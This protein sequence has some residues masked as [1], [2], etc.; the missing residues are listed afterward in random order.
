MH[1]PR[2]FNSELTP[3]KWWDWK[4]ILSCWGPVYFQ[5]LVLL[6][7]TEI[8]ETSVFTTGGLKT[9]PSLHPINTAGFSLPFDETEAI[10]ATTFE[11]SDSMEK[12][13]EPQGKCVRLVRSGVPS[14]ATGPHHRRLRRKKGRSSKFNLQGGE[15]V[16]HDYVGGI[17]NKDVVAWANSSHLPQLSK[18]FCQQKS[19]KPLQKKTMLHL[20]PSTKSLLRES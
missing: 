7:S 13:Q 4:T 3:E 14:G 18:E 6:V 9:T 16:S 10:I 17:L 15:N 20:G 19:G 8:I 5:V 1:T 12:R 11:N 2:K